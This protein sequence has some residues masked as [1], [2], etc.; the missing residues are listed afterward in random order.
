MFFPEELQRLSSL[1]ETK[2]WMEDGNPPRKVLLK[3]V[4]DVEGLICLGSDRIDAEVI[5]TASKLKVISSFSNGTDNI[6]I[7]AAT[8]RDIPVGHPPYVLTETTAD[9]GFALLLAAARRIVEGEAFVRQGK[10]KKSSHLD[11]PGVD[12]NHKTLGIVGMGRIGAQVAKRGKAFNMRVC[13]HN[14]QR[15]P[16]VENLLGI[17][18]FPSLPSLLAQ[19]DFIIL[20]AHLNPQSRHLIGEPEFAVMKPTAIL[21]NIAR[22]ALVDSRALYQ[23]LKDRRILRAAIDVTEP[24]PIALDDPLLTL[25]NLLI[26]PHIGSAVPDTRRQMMAI[27]VDHLILGLQGKR[28]LFCVNPI[29]YDSQSERPL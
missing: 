8:A 3:E 28:M 25:D 9:L 14:R 15:Q 11:L 23:A 2:I 20:C 17:E 7:A 10:W 6:D 21:V 29:V 27:A 12:V 26:A 5:R 18:Y 16:E 22:G 4:G 19:S 24:E 1:H 13:Y